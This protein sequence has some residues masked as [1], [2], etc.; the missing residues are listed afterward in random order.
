[1]D[2]L[3]I[4]LDQLQD[5]LENAAFLA[6]QGSAKEAHSEIFRC[7]TALSE[8]RQL[9]SM[10]GARQQSSS[11]P[12]TNVNDEKYS[13]EV[14]K[15]SNRLKKWAARQ[16]QINS[17]ILNAFLDLEKLG[18]VTESTLRRECA[19]LNFGSNF[20]Q[21]KIIAAGNHGKIFDHRGDVV[22][23]W[24]PIVQYVREYEKARHQ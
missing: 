16:D 2:A 10:I 5:R 7:T 11:N 15:V 17:K 22:T 13:A 24:P 14:K 18:T 9:C 1:M 8:I 19:E 21:M 23:L 12:E 4:K 3:A 20:A 6:S